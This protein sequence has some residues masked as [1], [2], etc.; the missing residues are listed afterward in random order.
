MGIDF[1]AA[2]LGNAFILVLGAILRSP[3]HANK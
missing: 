3:A 2:S 1:T